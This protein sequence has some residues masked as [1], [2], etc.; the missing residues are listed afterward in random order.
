MGLRYY[1]HQLSNGASLGYVHHNFMHHTQLAGLGYGVVI[2]QSDV[3]IEANRFNQGRHHIASSGRPGSS[4]EAR[5]NLILENANSHHFD[6]HGARDYEK[7][8]QMAVY[9]FDESGGLVADDAA[10]YTDHDCDLE[11]LTE[12]AWVPGYVGNAIAFS[13]YVE[14]G[15]TVQTYLNYEVGEHLESDEG[16][17]SLLFKADA[18]PNRNMDLLY[19]GNSSN[20]SSSTRLSFDS[21]ACRRQVAILLEH[22]D[23]SKVALTTS[24]RIQDTEWH[25]L[26]FT[27]DGTGVR[28]YVDGVLDENTAG[29]NSEAWTDCLA[30]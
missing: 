22:N 28:V 17:I 11:I 24:V 4:Y 20:S 8:D 2:N 18:L 23:A 13:P 30:F 19:L 3:L 27:Q 16:S 14:N 29:I 26:A 1:R 25:H 7:R 21:I 15:D 5:Y 9:K 6:M 10:T 12:S